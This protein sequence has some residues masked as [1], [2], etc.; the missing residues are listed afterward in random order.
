MDL[1]LLRRFQSQ[2]EFQCEAALVAADLINRGIQQQNTTIIFSGIQH[3]L[4]AAAN[5]SK[6][7]WGQKGK[8]AAQRMPLRDSIGIADNSPV[9]DVDMRNNWDHFDDRL[10]TWWSDSVKH[11]HADRIVG[12]IAGLDEKDTFRA[13]DPSTLDVLFWGDKFNLQEIVNEIQ[14]I[15]PGVKRETSKPHWVP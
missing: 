3:F 6:A 15:L 11:N 13:L 2:I 7:C 1:M 12:N 9:R 5:I 8:R 14:R 4:G 10:D